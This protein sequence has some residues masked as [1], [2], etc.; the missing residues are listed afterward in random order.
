MV[1]GAAVSA[2]GGGGSGGSVSAASPGCGDVPVSFFGINHDSKSASA[3]DGIYW[4][5]FDGKKNSLTEMAIAIRPADFGNDNSSLTEFLSF[6]LK[7]LFRVREFKIRSP[8]GFNSWPRP[9]ANYP[10]D[11]LATLDLPNPLHDVDSKISRSTNFKAL[12]L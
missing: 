6:F 7:P 11:T 5:G 9:A 8:G 2:G 12:K 10:T 4:E 3:E 1:R